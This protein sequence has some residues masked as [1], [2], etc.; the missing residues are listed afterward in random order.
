[1]LIKVLDRIA[2]G[3][4]TP[5]NGLS[6]FGEVEIYDSST[7]K[8]LID[9]ISNA[10]VIVIN[11]LKIT[12]EV[13]DAAKSLKLICIFATGYDNIDVAYAKEKGIAVCNVPGYSTDSVVLFTV[14]NVLALYS[15]LREYNDY[16]VSGEYTRSGK[17]NLLTPVYHEMRGKTWGIIGCGNI[18]KGVAKVAETLGAKVITYQRH[19]QE[20]YE[21]VAL[22]ELC[23]RSDIITIHCPL[24][25]D[26]RGIINMAKIK[27]MK[28]DVIIVNEARG[29]VVNEADIASALKQGLIGGYGSDV[30]SEEPFGE[31]HPFF[32]IKEMKN[33]ILTPHA[34]WGAYEARSR[35][36]DIICQNIDAYIN[37]K[38]LNRVDK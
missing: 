32:D 9:R 5:L 21:L 34:A 4:D 16:V 13:I 30:Y 15:H 37:G 2:I 20:G 17:A 35:C 12:G 1:M 27:L 22:E 7:N 18:G 28:P 26:S 29:A 3:M 25:A 24:N 8:E 6:K 10:E 19:K 33:V 23:K 31:K 38:I 11:K 14:A 36:I